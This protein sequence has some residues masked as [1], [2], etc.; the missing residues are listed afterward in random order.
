MV[1]FAFRVCICCF[2]VGK[3]FSV[4]EQAEFTFFCSQSYQAEGQVTGQG[5]AKESYRAVRLLHRQQPED[6]EDF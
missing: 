2:P 5:Q 6:H 3:R 1:L 4:T